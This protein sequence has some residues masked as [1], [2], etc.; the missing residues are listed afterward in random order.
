MKGMM[1]NSEKRPVV[2]HDSAIHSK[3]SEKECPFSLYASL[4]AIKSDLLS[5][6]E[7]CVQLSKKNAIKQSI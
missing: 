4:Y 6:C 5:I 2:F 1:L 7:L 3:S